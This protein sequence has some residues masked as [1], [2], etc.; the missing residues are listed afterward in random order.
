MVDDIEVTLRECAMREAEAPFEQA[1]RPVDAYTLGNHPAFRGIG[2]SSRAGVDGAHAEATAHA[3]AAAA[4]A[5][6]QQREAIVV[7]VSIYHIILV[8]IFIDIY[9]LPFIIYYLS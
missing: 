1:A 4:A 7:K 3:E 9:H 8:A 5:R 2:S 6:R